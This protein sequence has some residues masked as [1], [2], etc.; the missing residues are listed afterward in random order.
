MV[1]LVN[2]N[3]GGYGSGKRIHKKGI[4]DGFPYS[5][6]LSLDVNTFRRRGR[7][8][9]LNGV[10]TWKIGDVKRASV[11][12]IVRS[13]AI[14][15]SW[16][17]QNNEGFEQRL[18]LTWSAVNYGN[19]CFVLCPACQIR[20]TKLYAGTYFYCRHCYNLTYESCQRSHDRF[21]GLLGLTDKQHRN[22]RK[23]MEYA[24]ELEGRKWV[25]ARMLRRLNTYVKKSNVR[26]QAHEG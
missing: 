21:S 12:Y 2:Q 13:D 9:Y 23:A 16:R 25:G 15:L 18:P 17:N 6:Y 22:F 26:F 11:G 5:D 4:V 20:V 7:W 14:I 19:R 8:R 1:V 10:L 3:M 24:R